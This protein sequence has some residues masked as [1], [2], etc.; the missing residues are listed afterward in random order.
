MILTVRYLLP[1]LD[2]DWLRG[3]D[4]VLDSHAHHEGGRCIGSGVD[5]IYQERDREYEFPACPQRFLRMAQELRMQ[6][7]KR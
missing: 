5:L 1:D 6:V 3:A 2:L 4:A 7:K